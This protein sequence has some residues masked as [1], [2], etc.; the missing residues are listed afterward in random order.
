MA[1]PVDFTRLNTPKVAFIYKHM[2]ARQAELLWL[3][4]SIDPSAS[5]SEHMEFVDV[6]PSLGRLLGRDKSNPW[7]ITAS[8]LTG[9][10]SMCVRYFHKDQLILRPLTGVEA[11]SMIGWHPTFYRGY[12]G[13]TQETLA[14]LAGN[15]FSAFAFM[16][17]LMVSVSGLGIL[18]EMA[19]LAK[20]RPLPSPSTPVSVEASDDGESSLGRMDLP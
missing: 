6:N 18:K 5:D 9:M 1:W 8:T 14:N 10:S 19:E 11:I 4:N 15:A 20:R 17:M 3:C 16:P 7:K 12:V 2:T 13:A